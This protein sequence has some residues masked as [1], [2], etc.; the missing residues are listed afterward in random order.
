MQTAQEVLLREEA[1]VR[2][3]LGGDM[4]STPQPTLAGGQSQCT[5]M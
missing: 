3:N 5:N 2:Y 4:G 1:K